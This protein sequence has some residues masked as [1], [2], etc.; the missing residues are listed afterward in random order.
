MG[1]DKSDKGG[2]RGV[3]LHV[4]DCRVFFSP[5]RTLSHRGFFLFYDRSFG[6]IATLLYRDTGIRIGESVTIGD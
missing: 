5:V 2:G 1:T 6:K 3:L 4:L